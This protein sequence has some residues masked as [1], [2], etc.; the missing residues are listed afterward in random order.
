VP[1]T[2]T[3]DNAATHPRLLA[4]DNV[5]SEAAC[6]ENRT[7][8]GLGITE[9]HAIST[10]VPAYLERYQPDGQFARYRG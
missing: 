9:P 6:Q 5:V 10:I 1:W 3:G 7:L 2:R 4:V 8:A